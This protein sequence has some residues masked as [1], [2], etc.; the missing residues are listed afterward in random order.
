V[1]T[2]YAW[3]AASCDPCPGPALSAED[4]AALGA[5]VLPGEDDPLKPGMVLTRLHA[6]YTKEDVAEDL[7]FRAA[8][9]IA[10]GREIYATPEGLERGA[11][12]DTTNNFQGRYAV[13]HRWEG[14][15][16]CPNPIR[17]RWEARPPIPAASLGFVVPPPG[18]A[19][20]DGDGPD[21]PET[22]DVEGPG[23][24][25]PHGGCAACAVGGTPGERL[26]GLAA[27][28]GVAA[29]VLRRSRR[30]RPW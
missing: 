25:P 5:E 28:V 14:E 22:V 19:Q 16:H 8:P 27:I 15:T 20:P 13:R 30:R 12:P 3:D 18:D 24:L 10:G 6:R 21:D 4:L 23:P 9:P 11:H 29:L 7:V 26:G 1:F 2:E 17:G